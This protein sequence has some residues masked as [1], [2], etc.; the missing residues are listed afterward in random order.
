MNYI[1]LNE[2]GM[3]EYQAHLRIVPTNE[4]R[5]PRFQGVVEGGE[6]RH[7]PPPRNSSFGGRLEDKTVWDE[8]MEA[9]LR[10]VDSGPKPVEVSGC[11][12]EGP[13]GIGQPPVPSDRE[14]IVESSALKDDLQLRQ[15][16]VVNQ[17]PIAIEAQPSHP[18]A[19]APGC[20]DR[21]TTNGLAI[22]I[23]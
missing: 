18:P 3:T 17:D 11:E 7:P 9:L 4:S 20:M 13:N 8:V 2:N 21:E 10:T 23:E 5:L 6:T 16:I 1:G 22:T 19:I 14:S 12:D 15:P